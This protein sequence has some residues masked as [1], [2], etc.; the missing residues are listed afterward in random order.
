MEPYVAM[1]AAERREFLVSALPARAL[2]SVNAA[3][4]AAPTRID[5]LEW[6]ASCEDVCRAL[7]WLA[8]NCAGER[9]RAAREILAI[10][11]GLP[12]A[13]TF[14]YAGYKGGSEGGVLNQ[15]WLLERKDGAR[16]ALSASWN[17]QEK[18]LDEARFFGLMERVL[19]MAAGLALEE[20][21]K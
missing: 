15:S 19:G 2:E 7:D 12:G 21:P 1:S 11:P 20:A 10:N 13:K 5:A 18:A 8:R 3:V 4:L 6:F 14:A 9:T 16:F 17:D